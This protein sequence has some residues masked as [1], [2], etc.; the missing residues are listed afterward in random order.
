MLECVASNAAR[1]KN[2]SA[3][4]TVMT[5]HNTRARMFVEKFLQDAG[6]EAD[7]VFK[8]DLG[9]AI[10]EL[11]DEVTE[12]VE[13]ATKA[14][15]RPLVWKKASASDS[16]AFTVTTLKPDRPSV[17]VELLGGQA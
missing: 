11:L 4:G 16:S 2:D 6:A 12:E 1:K 15:Q 10:E 7:S 13:D 5:S 9:N 14:R 3:I 8:C 17:V